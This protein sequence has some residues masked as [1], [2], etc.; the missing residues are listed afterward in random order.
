MGRFKNKKPRTGFSRPQSTISSGEKRI[1]KNTKVKDLQKDDI[2]AG[3]GVVKQIFES[4]DGTWYIEAGESTADCFDP[5]LGFLAF[6]RKV[7]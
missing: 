4:C 3:M 1:W 5:D 7:D 6:V 2:I